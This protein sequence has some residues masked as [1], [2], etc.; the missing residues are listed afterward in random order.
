MGYL[1]DT[2]KK[3]TTVRSYI[4]AI[5]MVLLAEGIKLKE[6]K[7]LLNSLT[8]ACKYMND[9]VVPKLPTWKN[10]LN[11]ILNTTYELYMN[12]SNQP[13]LC[14]LYRAILSTAYYGLLRVGELTKGE[15]PVLAKDVFIANNKNKMLFILR[16]SKTHWTD[17]KPQKVKITSSSGSKK[18]RRNCPFESL[19]NILAED[20]ITMVTTNLSSY[21]VTEQQW[22]RN[23]LML[24]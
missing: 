2:K 23:I 9:R 22:N 13:Y 10:L 24:L 6:D 18:R 4:S 21:S 11:I 15:H 17:S 1:V 12:T 14:F 7:Y 3:S 8:R 16:T 20:Q 5:K 19:E